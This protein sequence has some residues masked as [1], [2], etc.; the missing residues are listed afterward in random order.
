MQCSYLIHHDSLKKGIRK[1]I[2]KDFI[3]LEDRKELVIICG[4]TITNFC[5]DGNIDAL[6]LLQ[7]E[8]VK[9]H[10]SFL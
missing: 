4:E 3:M 7:K 9:L 2:M 10:M 1:R 5:F 6:T 8:L